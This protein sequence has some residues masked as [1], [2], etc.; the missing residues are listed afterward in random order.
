M[1]AILVNVYT[2]AE[3]YSFLLVWAVTPLAYSLGF[4]YFVRNFPIEHIEKSKKAK[5][6]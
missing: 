1:E 3:A 4:F 2:F 6:A 5:N